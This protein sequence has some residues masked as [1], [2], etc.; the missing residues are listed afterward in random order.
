MWVN[1]VVSIAIRL[2]VYGKSGSLLQSTSDVRRKP[3][4]IL[5][6]RYAHGRPVPHTYLRSSLRVRTL[7]LPEDRWQT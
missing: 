1:G 7:T 5:N 2:N 4:L 3:S 6:N